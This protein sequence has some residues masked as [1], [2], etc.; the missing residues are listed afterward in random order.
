LVQLGLATSNSEAKRSIQQGAVRINGDKIVDPDISLSLDDGTVI[1][2]G[3]RRFAKVR[4][5]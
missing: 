2:V 4:I 3:K 1:Q 5:I